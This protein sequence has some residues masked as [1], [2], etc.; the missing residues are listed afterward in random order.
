MGEQLVKCDRC[1]Q[2]K[3]LGK[4]LRWDE[5]MAHCKGLCVE[6]AK[7]TYDA[8]H[9]WPESLN[10]TL[11]DIN[12]RRKNLEEQKETT[13]EPLK[14]YLNKQGFPSLAKILDDT[15]E[16]QEDFKKK[17]IENGEVDTREPQEGWEEE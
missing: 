17:L 13:T 4:L 15:T 8:K 3:T 10:K 11:D 9:E 16:P 5:D 12:E 1:G 2:I 6:C 7:D 14:K